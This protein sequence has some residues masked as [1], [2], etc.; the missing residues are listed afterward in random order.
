[1]YVN[2][3]HYYIPKCSIVLSYIFNPAFIYLL[4]SDKT[5]QMGNYRFLLITFAIFNMSCSMCDV[6]VPMCVHDHQYM[7]MVYISDGYFASKSMAGQWAIAIRCGF[8]SCT[9]GILNVHFVF[10]YLALRR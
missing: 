9:Y 1:M 5:S 7:F 6:F 10:R 8:I 3:A 2:W 4:I